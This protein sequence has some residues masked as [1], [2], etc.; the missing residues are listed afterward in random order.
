MRRAG[1]AI[2]GFGTVGAGVADCLLKRRETIARRTGTDVRLVRVADLDTT[3]DRGVELPPGVLTADAM[4]AIADPEVDLVVETIGGTGVAKKFQLAALEAGKALV[5]A[6]KKLLAECGREIFEAAARRKAFLGFGAAVGGGIPVVRVVKDALAGNTFTSIAGILNGTCNYILTRMADEGL[7]FD[8]ALAEAQRLGYAEA[9]PSLDV[10]G[11]DSA[12]KICI[13][14]NL[15]FGCDI[16]PSDIEVEGIRGVTKET[17]GRA[18]AKGEAVKLVARAG[19]GADGK[20]AASVRPE[21]ISRSQMLAR[22]DGVFNAVEIESEP[23]GKTFYA[24]RGAGRDP[25]ASTIVGDIC[26]W[27]RILARGEGKA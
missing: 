12:H 11:W 21:S 14:A 23:A 6:N 24:G 10:D 5:T 9:D 2:L 17:I 27:A 18:L 22:V 16:G 4:A 1:V 26:D 8:E 13:L 19:I 3:S 15:A 7:A 25:T 20:V